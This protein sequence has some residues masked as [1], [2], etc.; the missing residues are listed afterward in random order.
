MHISLKWEKEALGMVNE[1]LLDHTFTIVRG[2][3][4]PQLWQREAWKEFEAMSAEEKRPIIDQ[5]C[6]DEVERVST[7]SAISMKGYLMSSPPESTD[8]R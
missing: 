4:F 1:A 6:K 5:I 7:I 8:D 3:D 2:P